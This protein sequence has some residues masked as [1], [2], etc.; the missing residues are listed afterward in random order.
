MTEDTE[1]RP[2]C[3]DAADRCPCCKGE[4]DDFPDQDGSCDYQCLHC[5]WSE[6]VPGSCEIAAALLL[7]EGRQASALLTA[8]PQLLTVGETDRE[9]LKQQA[10]ILGKV[11]DKNPLT[12]DERSCLEGLWEFVHRII[13]RL[14]TTPEPG[15][16]LHRDGDTVAR[17]TVV[18]W[19][20][21][22]LIQ[23]VGADGPV[24][25]IACDWDCEE[26]VATRIDGKPCVVSDW[27]PPDRPNAAF[28]K[29]LRLADGECRRDPIDRE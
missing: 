1:A 10:A 23:G 4:I 19:V 21:G 18:V 26:P 9:L 17:P 25:V 24:R 14:E 11:V 5:G 7:H 27:N 20:K 15:F 16:S 13:D 8:G 28:N 2:A 3:A 22:G 12:G 6:H 29:V